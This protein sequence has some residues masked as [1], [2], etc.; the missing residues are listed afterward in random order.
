MAVVAL[1]VLDVI[2]QRFSDALAKVTENFVVGL[3]SLIVVLAF[4][5]VAWLVTKLLL[6]VLHAFLESVHLEQKLKEK[7]VD[8]A[9]LGFSVTKVLSL[10]VKLLTYAVFL[11]MAA[12]VVNLGFLKQLINWFVGYVPLV[13][14]G[15]TILVLAMLGGDY[16]TDKVKGSKLPFSKLIGV[17]LEVF[18]VYSALVIALPLLLPN[19]EVDILRSTFLLVVGAFAVAFGAGLAIAIGLGMKDTVAS[20]AKNRQ[21]TIEK[22][23]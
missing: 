3:A 21:R 1:M 9:L 10:F 22:L 15:A 11:G 19:A 16:I 2:S 6:K 7:G 23:V 8:D 18:I 12:D 13:V 14:Q 5:F 20:I 17:L 4:L